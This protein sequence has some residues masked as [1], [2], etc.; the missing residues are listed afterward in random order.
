MEISQQISQHY[1]KQQCTLGR[2]LSSDNN[3]FHDTKDLF[4]CFR[5]IESQYKDLL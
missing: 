4:V 3:H 1:F 2:Q 5:L